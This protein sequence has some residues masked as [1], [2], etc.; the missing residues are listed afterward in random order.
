MP[1]SVSTEVSAVRRRRALRRAGSSTV[2]VMVLSFRGAG[3]AMREQFQVRSASLRAA[4]REAAEAAVCV[5]S[6]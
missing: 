6:R 5:G 1:L 3:V 2:S 4:S